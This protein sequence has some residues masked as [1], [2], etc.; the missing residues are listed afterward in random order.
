MKI[1]FNIAL[2]LRLPSTT[3]KNQIE[4]GRDTKVLIL[5]NERKQ[6]LCAGKACVDGKC[7]KYMF[8]M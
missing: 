3:F 2:N 4:S 7:K 1:N 6:I 5:V 8:V